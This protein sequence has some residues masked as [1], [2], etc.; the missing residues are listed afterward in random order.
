M[1]FRVGQQALATNVNEAFFLLSVARSTDLPTENLKLKPQIL[2]LKSKISNLK[3][4][5]SNLKSKISNLESEISN[6][7]SQIRVRSGRS[8]GRSAW[9]PAWRQAWRPAWRPAWK[10]SMGGRLRFWCLRFCCRAPRRSTERPTSN[11]KRLID[12]FCKCLLTSSENHCIAYCFE[13]ILAKSVNKYKI[14]E[15]LR[16]RWLDRQIEIWAGNSEISNMDKK[17]S[18][19]LMFWSFFFTL[20]QTNV[21]KCKCW[22][23]LVCAQNL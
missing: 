11:K 2:N 20:L 4:K 22:F 12:I 14:V 18:H 21:K 5:I 7:K 13:D 9:R 6:L 15:H 17:H 8:V 10:K 1:V 23:F 19:T 3:S 16:L